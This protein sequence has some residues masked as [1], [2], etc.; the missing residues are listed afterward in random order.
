VRGLGGYAC[1]PTS[2]K[3]CELKKDQFDNAIEKGKSVQTAL[4]EQI[5]PVCQ[6][7]GCT[8]WKKRFKLEILGLKSS[9]FRKG[10]TQE[11]G[12]RKNKNEEK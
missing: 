1:D 3:R 5:C 11:S 9:D 2:D 7:F 4:D 10:R 6:L 8:G 12:L